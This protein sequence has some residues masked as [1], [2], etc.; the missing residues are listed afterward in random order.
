[1]RVVSIQLASNEGETKQNRI[2][3]A[4][5]LLNDLYKEGTR[6]EQILFPEVWATGFFNTKDYQGEAEQE[7]GITYDL[8]SSWAEKF[9]AY[10][11]T[12]SFVEKEDEC[13]YNTSLLIDPKGKV[14]GKYRKIHLFGF[15][16]EETKV[17]NPG[18]RIEVVRTEYGK[19]GLSTCYDLRFPELFRSM[20]NLGAEYFLVTS[21][22]PI[23]RLAHWKLFNQVRA[24]E[25]QSFIISCN[26]VGTI[27]GTQLG[28]HSMVV[29]PW[30]EIIASANSEETVISCE[31][32]P[33]EIPKNRNEFPALKDKK[34]I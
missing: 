33:N 30:G 14:V 15:Q 34:L 12:G 16:S 21:A 4:D 9:N 32:D 18:S 31:I 24:I 5:S 20:V 13:Y 11:H 6:P 3:R 8:I 25:N 22:W 23:A 28:G 27:G 1:M 2:D 17:L 19:V 10:I 7:K 29:N 26:G